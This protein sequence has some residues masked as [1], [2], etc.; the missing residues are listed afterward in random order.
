MEITLTWDAPFSLNLT[1]DPD[2]AY[3]VDVHNITDEG[4]GCLIL[5]VCNVLST[6]FV[7]NSTN[8]NPRDYFQFTII[9]RSN[10][11][12]A[13]NGTP[14]QPIVA[15]FLGMVHRAILYTQHLSHMI[16]NLLFMTTV[17]PD[18]CIE[19]I[20]FN[21]NTVVIL[22]KLQLIFGFPNWVINANIDSSCSACTPFVHDIV[23]LISID[24][25]K[26]YGIPL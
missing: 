21:A 3:C 11:P 1:S 18:V 19:S 23:Y 17:H 12:G 6:Y 16:L 5:S 2:V 20:T 26:S 13:R 4:A 8:P 25:D 22:G 14:S 10:V 9:P 24:T 7:Y 15:S